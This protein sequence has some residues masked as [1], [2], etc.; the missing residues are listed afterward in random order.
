LSPKV[1]IIIP[2]FNTGKYLP[3]TIKSVEVQTYANTEI[4][5]IDNGSTDKQTKTVL[6]QLEKQHKVIYSAQISVSEARNKAVSEST[7]SLVLPLDSDDTI[8]PIFIE[9]CVTIFEQKPE[10]IVVRTQVNLFGKKTG[11]L[12]LPDYSFNL[13]L[14]RNL[15]VVTSMFKRSNFDAI[16]GFDSK[17]V[18]G[19]EDWEFWINLLQN[20]GEV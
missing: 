16:G 3:E 18:N 2:V 12:N 13:L 8:A 17:F 6:N 19:F 10:T 9:K 11:Y 7:G 4:I 14:A 5:L 1:S 20:G 15:M